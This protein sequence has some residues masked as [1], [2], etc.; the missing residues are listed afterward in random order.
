LGGTATFTL[1]N[2]PA[3]ADYLIWASMTNG[4]FILPGGL[5]LGFAW[6]SITTTFLTTTIAGSPLTPFLGTLDGAGAGSAVLTI[7]GHTSP[8]LLDDLDI[9]FVYSTV[10]PFDFVSNIVNVLVVAYVPPPP[11]YFYDDGSSE[12]SLGLTAGGSLGWAHWF[13][14]VP[15]NETIAEIQSTFGSCPAGSN[16]I[17]CLWDDPNNDGDMLDVGAP[18]ASLPGVTANESTDI[19]NTYDITDT[20]VASRFFIGLL[21]TD[22]LPAGNYPAPMDQD[23]LY[24][25]QA[26]IIGDTLGPIDPNNIAGAELVNEMST[27]GWPFYF[28]LRAY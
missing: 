21:I 27:I 20:V 11:G 19:F 12:N 15:G 4:L 17:A 23:T 18:L 25:G 14:V 6:D 22:M 16:C 10:N 1:S 26:W 24:G 8:P 3:G 2:G 9:M 5:P 28:L 7:P 13:D